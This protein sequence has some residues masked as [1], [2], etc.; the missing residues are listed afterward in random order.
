[1]IAS[2]RPYH[3]RRC[4]PGIVITR[5]RRR[6]AVRRRPRALLGARQPR[7][8]RHARDHR[9]RRVRLRLPRRRAASATSRSTMCRRSTATTSGIPAIA[10]I[11][12]AIRARR[13]IGVIAAREAWSDAGLR[14]RRAGRRRRD[15]QRRRRHRR[16]RAAVPRLL[17]RARQEGHA[18]RD[19]DLDRRHGVERD[20]DFAAAAR[21][22]PRAVVRLHE[23]DRRD[24]LRG[25]ADPRRARPTS[26]CRA[27]PTRAS[28]PGMIFGFSRM[29]VVSTAYNDDAGRGVAAVR[30]G[31]R[32]LRARRRRVD[33]RARARGSRAGARRARSTRRST[34]TARPATRITACR[35]RRTARRSCAR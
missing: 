21:R 32:R 25:G 5:H 30:P 26:C 28:R 9:F 8:Q 12:S 29:H 35:W 6:L 16:R 33:G 19:P 10:P 34:A 14:D 22:Q 1:M 4:L 18:V 24:R 17:R 15:R 20:F 23:L 7:L 31:A 3:R 2:C 13:S 27:A 11:R